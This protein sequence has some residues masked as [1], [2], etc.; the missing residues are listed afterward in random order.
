V[1]K[2]HTLLSGALRREFQ[3]DLELFKHFL[4]L[5][6]NTSPIRNVELMWHEEREELDPLKAKFKSRVGTGDALVQLQPVGAPEVNRNSPS[7][8]FCD[9]VHGFGAHEEETCARS[10]VPAKQRCRATGCTQVYGCHVGLTDIAVPVICDGQYLGTLFSG[11]VST[12]PPTPGG[13]RF[14]RETLKGQPH[15]NFKSLEAAYYQVPVVNQAQVAEMVRI[16]ELFAR[17]IS[18]SWKRLQLISEFQ[19]NHDRELSLDRKELASVLL[20]GD[21]GDLPELNALASRAGLRRLPE[22]VM[23]LQIENLRTDS[24]RQGGGPVQTLNRLSHVVEDFCQS[25]PNSLAMVVRPGE[26]C[27]FTS[28]E[29][30]NRSHERLSLEEMADSILAK[31]RLQTNATVRIG[32]SEEHRQPAELLKAYQEACAALDTGDTLVSFFSDPKPQKAQP[33][34]V[35]AQLVK[36]FQQGTSVSSVMREFLAL[37][38]PADHSPAELQRS[39]ALLTWAI[40]HLALE[41]VSCGVDPIQIKAAKEKATTSVLHAPSPFGACEAFRRFADLVSQQL[42]SAFSQREHKIVLAVS[43]VV[44]QRGAAQITIHELAEAVHLSCGHLSRVFRRTTGMTLEQFLIRQ[45]VELAKRAL[46]D[47]RFNVAEVAERCGFCNPAYFASVFKRYVKC[48]P[49]EFA[50]QPHRWEPLD[51]GPFWPRLTNNASLS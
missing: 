50:S 5:L 13:F 8:L 49:R 40:E 21:V 18:N 36:A 51:S 3:K 34:E 12:S 30:R 37:V 1:K 15:I 11:Q 39:R 32:I 38:M 31:V 43:Q 24:R 47:P 35:M 27:I 6:N 10:D 33:S 9:L 29:V 48:T 46:L 28:Q 20:S 7:T 26:V 23:V 45:R 22:R 2:Q 19:R 42:A 14:V 44:E 25:L 4:L 41:T 17:Y 16:L